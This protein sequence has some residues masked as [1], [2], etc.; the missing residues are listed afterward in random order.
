MADLTRAFQPVDATLPDSIGSLTSWSQSGKSQHRTTQQVGRW[1]T[2]TYGIM[3]ASSATTRGFLA[4]LR[5]K[6]RA[7][8]IFTVQHPKMNT[9]LGAGG[10]TP[11][12][13]GASQ[14]GSSVITDGWPNSTAILK[15]GDVLTIGAL[16]NVFDVTADV[17]SN[18]SGQAT[19]S[20]N[21][22][23]YSSPADNGAIVTSA[24][25]FF[26]VRLVAMDVP[27]VGVDGFY[28]GMQ[29]TFRESMV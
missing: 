18:G 28:R 11:L 9:L 22:P 12:V 14:L 4:D 19:I 29:L 10:G 26:R 6:L 20:I 2:E 25:V 23:M 17:S 24:S 7:G 15:A 1:W 16:L 27:T 5:A 21:P 3:T 13:N 8:T